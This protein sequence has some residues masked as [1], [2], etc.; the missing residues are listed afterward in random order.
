M[1]LYSY[2]VTDDTGFA[3]N[4]F[5]GYCT[6]ACCK[7]DIRRC[8][9]T[10][11]WIVGLTPKSSGN[12]IVYFMRVDE[13]MT[14]DG[15][16]HDRASPKNGLNTSPGLASRAAIISTS[17]CETAS[18]DRLNQ[19]IRTEPKKTAGTNTDLRGV[20]VL[21]S[22]TF[23]YFGSQALPLPPELLPLKIGKKHR[24][25]FSDGVKEDFRRFAEQQR[26]G[27]HARPGTWPQ[28]DSSWVQFSN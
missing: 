9:Q 22:E 21:V 1:T 7:P 6:L 24:C 17:L 25:N 20:K 23:A 18:I 3:P 16:W 10:G 11:D 28:E 15:Y 2:I 13:I 5:F 12:G 19:I 26:F 27:V 8:A 4:P 14:F